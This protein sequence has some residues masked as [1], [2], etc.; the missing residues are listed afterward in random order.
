MAAEGQSGKMVFGIEVHMKQR[1][2]IEFLLVEKNCTQ[3]TFIDT[4][5]TFMKTKQWGSGWYISVVVT[6][7]WNTSHVLHGSA[8][9]SH[10]EMKSISISSSTWIRGLWPGNCTQSWILASV[11]CKQLWQCWIIAK[12]LPDGSHKC[13]HRKRKN[14]VCI[15]VRKYWTNMRLKVTVS[16]IVSLQVTR[17]VVTTKSW[18]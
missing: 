2:G 18:N 15:F 6:V 4:F 10:H 8:Q 13:S 1:C 16:W 9:L 14:T 11:H 3:M 7:I 5:L 17:C 12:F